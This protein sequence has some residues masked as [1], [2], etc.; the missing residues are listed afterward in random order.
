M[1]Q[2]GAAQ[3]TTTHCPT[4]LSSHLRRPR[5]SQAVLILLPEIWP[6]SKIYWCVLQFEVA[7][8]CGGGPYVS[9]QEAR[10][11]ASDSYSQQVL[12]S[13]S[14]M[15]KVVP[16][17]VGCLFISNDNLINTRDAAPSRYLPWIFWW[18]GATVGDFVMYETFKWQIIMK[19]LLVAPTAHLKVL[20]V[21]SLRDNCIIESTV[22]FQDWN[23][24]RAGPCCFP[25]QA[26]LT[27]NL[28]SKPITGCSQ[29]D[30][31][32]KFSILS[33]KWSF[34]LVTHALHFH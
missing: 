33:F 2:T 10:V 1:R 18:R 12:L 26:M 8:K 3:I 27:Q 23:S 22:P 4:W 32:K 29:S 5:C 20:Y 16:S 7:Q 14:T 24:L 28:P 25:L 31:H 9:L 17:H 30:I 11:N 21:K 13:V 6:P 15:P 34:P 19:N